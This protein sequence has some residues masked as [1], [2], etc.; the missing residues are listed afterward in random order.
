MLYTIE[1][2]NSCKE[3]VQTGEAIPGTSAKRFNLRVELN[4]AQIF[5]CWM[6]TREDANY[7]EALLRIAFEQINPARFSR[8]QVH[9]ASLDD[10]HIA[11]LATWCTLAGTV[12]LLCTA[13]HDR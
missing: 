5:S 12:L 8:T 2:L 7:L 6:E 11:S 10:S 4:G 3:N 13:S 9:A 1:R